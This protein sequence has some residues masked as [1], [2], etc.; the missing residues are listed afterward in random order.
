[1]LNQALMT[2]GAVS[3]YPVINSVLESWANNT[4]AQTCLFYGERNKSFTYY[5]FNQLCEKAASGL[6]NQGITKGDRVSVLTSNA[7]YTVLMMFACWKVG[8]LYCPINN[9][10]KNDLLVYIINDTK[11]AIVYI[12]QHFVGAI[13]AIEQQIMGRPLLVVQQ[14]EPG[15][16]DYSP[17]SAS[18]SIQSFKSISLN[19][20]LTSGDDADDPLS[21][22]SKIAKPDSQPD[23]PA[24]IIYTSGSTGNPKGVVQT[25]A[26]LSAC[27]SIVCRSV[28]DKTPL[29]SL[30][31]YNDLP[32][33][34]VGGMVYGV[35]QTLWN[36]DQLALWDSFSPSQFW[37]RIKRSGANVARFIDVMI[38][39]LMQQPASAGDSDNSLFMVAMTPLPVYHADFAARFGIDFI[40]AGYG[41]TEIGTGFFGLIDESGN[42]PRAALARE[43]GFKQL[44]IDRYRQL[45]PRA[46]IDGAAVHKKGFLG[47][48][49]PTMRS[50]ILN[51][52]DATAAVGEAG[53]VYFKPLHR[54]HILLEYFNQP[55]KTR[56]ALSEGW[57]C[58]ADRIRLD[59][60]GYYYFA[61]RQQG[62]LRVRGE[63]VSCE[64]IEQKIDG[65]PVVERTAVIGVDAAQGGGDDV[66]AFV[67]KK[68]KPSQGAPMDV[69]SGTEETDEQHLR[70]WIESELPKFMW[71]KT[72]CWV[73]EFPLTATYK[74][75]KPKL[76]QQFMGT[77]SA[78]TADLT[79]GAQRDD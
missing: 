59:A 60:D 68:T 65:H 9:R 35:V 73:E 56:E 69:M 58:P 16:H 70:R 32:L 37:Q 51:A 20:L 31:T 23:D 25:H 5:E 64:A 76:K 14:P 41:S 12:D 36:G 57:Y 48:A 62:F 66:V 22:A 1:M 42:S 77:L 50:K 38:D 47:V 34:H 71:P 24:C 39:W 29:P 78:T 21:N 15:D 10:Y 53:Q 63:N 4:P 54:N 75:D 3:S 18:D 43:H 19:Q 33:Y 74:I 28:D 8:A 30:I 11:P 44:F 46:V 79:K 17:D 40:L 72:I 49:N 7:L 52:D 26:W 45:D 13:N 55:D 67:Q 2:A 27:C 61:G 6:L